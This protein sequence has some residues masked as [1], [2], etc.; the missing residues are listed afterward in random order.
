MDEHCFLLIGALLDRSTSALR[1]ALDEIGRLDQRYWICAFCVNQH[2]GICGGFSKEPMLGT[3][4]HEEWR[5]KRCDTWTRL[6][7]PT[8]RCTTQKYFNTSCPLCVG[9]RLAGKSVYCEM[10]KFDD[11]IAFLFASREAGSSEF[12]QVIAADADFDIFNRAWCVKEIEQSQRLGLKQSLKVHSYQKLDC[13]QE[14]LKRLRIQDMQAS[15]P[16]DVQEI[17]SSIQRGIGLQEFNRSLRRL[18]FDEDI[19][20]IAR[21]KSADAEKRFEMLGWVAKW[22]RICE[23]DWSEVA[24]CA[25]EMFDHQRDYG[26]LEATPVVTRSLEGLSMRLVTGP[27]PSAQ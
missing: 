2:A 20:L 22:V 4:D 25:S 12:E 21:W 24:S 14:S 11:M 8:C 16:E 3:T 9:A 19:G 23:E 17:L 5:K 18:I 13:H 7:H 27:M 10:N 6:E 15:R 1:T 26:S